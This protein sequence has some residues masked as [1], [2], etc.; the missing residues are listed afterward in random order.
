MNV[1]SFRWERSRARPPRAQQL[2]VLEQQFIHVEHQ[3]RE[4][5]LRHVVVEHL[6]PVLS[7]AIR[8]RTPRCGGLV[9]DLDSPA[10]REC[11]PEN[12]SESKSLRPELRRSELGLD[13]VSVGLEIGDEG[14]LV[15]RSLKTLD[16]VGD[17]RFR[18]RS[19]LVD[20]HNDRRWPLVSIKR[21][22][23]LRWE[24]P[25][26]DALYKADLADALV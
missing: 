17:R 13:V 14:L 19:A 7:V 22:K 16:A 5:T 1:S 18:R 11:V 12:S 6:P 10:M 26:F 8:E 15:E 2:P 25:E 23:E 4:I 9:S 3:D 24:P 20:S 21:P